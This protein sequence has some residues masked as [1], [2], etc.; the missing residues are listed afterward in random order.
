MR[1]SAKPITADAGRFTSPPDGP[2]TAT[3]S[4][5]WPGSARCPPPDHP[6]RDPYQ[7]QQTDPPAGHDDRRART[8]SHTVPRNHRTAP[9]S[10]IK[11]LPTPPNPAAIPASDL[12]TLDPALRWI[13]AKASATS[14]TNATA[15]SSPPR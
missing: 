6:A 12:T 2:G 7:A 13:Q 4:P 1:E 14:E 9:R 10:A 8:P 15:W 11:Q 5:R 3:T